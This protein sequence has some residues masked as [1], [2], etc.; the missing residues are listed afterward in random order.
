MTKDTINVRYMIRD[1]KAA[2]DFYKRHL[3][4][5]IEMDM[6]PAFISVTRGQ[7]RL[8]LSGPQSSG[9]RPLPDGRKPE[10]GGW[11]RIQLLFDDL[12]AEVA[13]LKAAGVTF[14]SEIIGGPGGKQIV[15]DDP[16]GNPV[17]LFQPAER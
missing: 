8:L 9:A 3:G 2:A 12:A 5:E 17:E 16:S 14:R 15:L 7:L 4:F 13:R 10:P 11:N 6:A 1:V